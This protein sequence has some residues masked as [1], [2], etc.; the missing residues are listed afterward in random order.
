[1]GIY[2][3]STWVKY[4]NDPLVLVG[5]IIMLFA[6]ILIALMKKNVFHLSQPAAERI[7]KLIIYSAFVL[8]LVIVVFSFLYALKYGPINSEETIITQETKGKQSPNIITGTSPGNVSIEQKSSGDQSPNI[9]SNGKAKSV[10][11]N[12]D[13]KPVKK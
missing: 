13:N 12:Y 8:G 5:F 3:L 6:S 4:L 9:N 7:L 11:I 10:E 2:S 1:M